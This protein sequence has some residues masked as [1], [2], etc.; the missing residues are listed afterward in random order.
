MGYI[1]TRNT[2]RSFTST[3]FVDIVFSNP[4]TCYDYINMGVRIDS[5]EKRRLATECRRN[6]DSYTVIA[7]NLKL[8]KST[9]SG[10]LSNIP[11]VPNAN[12]VARIMNG[13]KKSAEIR[14]QIKLSSIKNVQDLARG[15]IGVLSKRDL[16]MFGTGLY[17][18]EGAKSIESVR[19]INS[20]PNVIRL[21]IA[22]LMNVCG[23]VIENLTLAVHTYP[24]NNIE[25][26]IKYWSRISGVPVS[27][28]GKT[29][30][31]MRLKKSIYH[32]NK[33]P[34]GTVQLRVR[35]RK[36]KKFGVFL[37]RRI[38]AWIEAIIQ[39]VDTMRD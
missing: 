7:K 19:F 39:Q 34:Y 8:S 18:G 5:I 2:S 37:H 4:L 10:W 6:G 23:V 26:T 1:G 31:D 28:F 15:E 36:N 9:L 22:W 12:T 16:W 14:H 20:D 3:I 25:S 21:C 32:R 38:T 13:P 30:V 24:D 35:A 33:L 11:Y 17:L 29:Q 27:E